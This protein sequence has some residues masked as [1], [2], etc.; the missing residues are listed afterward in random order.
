MAWTKQA[1]L[2]RNYLS[3]Y[4]EIALMSSYKVCSFQMPLIW[5]ETMWVDPDDW[6]IRGRP[7]EGA[8]IETLPGLEQ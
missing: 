5:I 7:F 1:T 8:W 3:L 6:I 4:K 2:N